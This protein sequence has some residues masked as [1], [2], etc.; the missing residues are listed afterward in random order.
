MKLPAWKDIRPQ[1][2]VYWIRLLFAVSAAFLCSPFILNLTSSYGV[3]IGA[4]VYAVSYYFFKNIM[5]IDAKAVGGT[6]KFIT[7]GIGSYIMIW[8]VFWTLLNTVA[9]FA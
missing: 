6:R 9:L 2:K 5:K 8:I 4:I 3:I 7:T 1:S